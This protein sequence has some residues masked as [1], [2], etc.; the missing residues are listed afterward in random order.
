MY[1]TDWFGFQGETRS[2]WV[3]LIVVYAL[4]VAAG[5]I[6]GYVKARSNVSLISGLGSGIV[7]AI[8]AKI[9]SNF[10]I[11]GVALAGLVA[12]IL[13][14]VFAIRFAKTRAFMPAGLMLIVSAI[15]TILFWAGTIDFLGKIS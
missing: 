8:A 10:P 6:F 12:L 4:I 3:G 13:V 14:V 5:G 9:T 15:A 2:F 7:L 11:G 1:I